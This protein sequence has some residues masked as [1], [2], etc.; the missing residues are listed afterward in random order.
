MAMSLQWVPPKKAQEMLG[1]TRRELE[2]MASSRKIRVEATPGGERSRRYSA[3]DIETILRERA[4]AS[5]ELFTADGHLNLNGRVS[6]WTRETFIDRLDSCWTF[7]M[8]YGYLDPE[9]AESL[10]L[11]IVADVERSGQRRRFLACDPPRGSEMG[12]R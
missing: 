1:V 3:E 8:A 7:L 10:R 6:D 2:K 4:D 12:G 11:K 5:P 9:W